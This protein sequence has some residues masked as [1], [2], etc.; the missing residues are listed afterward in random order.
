MLTDIA[1]PH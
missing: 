1:Q